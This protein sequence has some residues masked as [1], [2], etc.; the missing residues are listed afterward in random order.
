MGNFHVKIF[1]V[2]T[3]T[4][5]SICVH[6]DFSWSFALAESLYHSISIATAPEVL[7]QHLKL[8]QFQGAKIVI[9][10]CD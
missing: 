1:C 5:T 10:V 7:L 6:M 2:T 3:S 9:L 8:S 4:F